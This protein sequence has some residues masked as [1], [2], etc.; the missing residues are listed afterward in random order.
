MNIVIST[1]TNISFLI[2]STK[3]IQAIN[4]KITIINK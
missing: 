2:E 4:R 1:V 3:S